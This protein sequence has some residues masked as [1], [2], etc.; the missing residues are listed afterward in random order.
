MK[1]AETNRFDYPYR[2]ALVHTHFRA[3]GGAERAALM[4]LHALESKDV[5]VWVISRNWQKSDGTVRHIQ[6]NPLYLGRLWREWGFARAASRIARSGHFDLIQ[7]QIRFQGCDIYRAGGGVH[8]EWL[9]QRARI[10]NLMRRFLTRISPFHAYK[11]KTER[12]LYAD[13]KLK[14]VICNSQMVKD[15]IHS[16]FGLEEKK[17]HVIYNAVDTSYFTPDLVEIHRDSQ[18]RQLG[19]EPN[20]TVFL[21][22]GS[23]F[24]RKGLT[25]V[26]HCM[27]RLP[28]HDACLLVVGQDKHSKK[29]QSMARNLG[30]TAR[31]TFAG[32]QKDVRPYYAAADAFVL[33]TLYDAFANTVLEAM[34]CG[35][36]VIT[37][38][39]CGAVDLIQSGKNGFL[40]DALDMRSLTVLMNELCSADRRRAMGAAGRQTIKGLTLDRMRQHLLTLYDT[41]LDEKKNVQ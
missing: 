39:K 1:S 12:E 15:E 34:A 18:R 4:T 7:S 30:L 26:L 20:Q 5:Q 3:D 33:P 32:V 10:S 14:A 19:I 37:S 25:Q 6:C 16:W 9:R 40:C 22:V 24:E 2:V 29:Y 27:A 35:L 8:A 36:P 11:L 17:I 38:L 23:G 41:I 28:D 21:F 31:V 13:S